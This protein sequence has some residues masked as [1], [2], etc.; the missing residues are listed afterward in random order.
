MTR[1]AMKPRNTPRTPP[2]LAASA[3]GLMALLSA[4]CRVPM[5]VSVAESDFATKPTNYR[6]DFSEAH[7]T[8]YVTFHPVIEALCLGG[9]RL[10][11]S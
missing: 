10:P 11:H 1:T 4:S 2:I 8:Q 9:C 5:D 7:H 3:T 6:I